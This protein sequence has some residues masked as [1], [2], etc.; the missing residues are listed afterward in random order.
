LCG[1]AIGRD[2]SSACASH[3]PLFRCNESLLLRGIRGLPWL[4]GCFTPLT[5]R[6]DHFELRQGNALVERCDPGDEL[7][8][9]SHPGML[10]PDEEAFMLTALVK[11]HRNPT[12]SSRPEIRCLSL[13][14]GT[15]QGVLEAG[16]RK[17]ALQTYAPVFLRRRASRLYG[18]LELRQG[19]IQDGA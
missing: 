15:N 4:P 10:L 17:P 16:R 14:I 11:R 12:G 5:R 18:G 8:G 1:A 9:E 19:S 13:C 7:S 2:V 3:G 6:F